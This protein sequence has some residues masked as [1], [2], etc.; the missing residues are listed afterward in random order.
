MLFHLV[1]GQTTILSS[2][3]DSLGLATA[4][5]HT[6]PKIIENHF[7]FNKGFSRKIYLGDT[8][9][10]R[11]FFIVVVGVQTVSVSLVVGVV[12]ISISWVVG[13]IPRWIYFWWVS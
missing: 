10:N 6:E 1:E 12:D 8:E 2:H 4:T 5:Y 7:N 3:P 11:I 9:L 13:L